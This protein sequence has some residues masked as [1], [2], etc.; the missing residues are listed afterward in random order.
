VWALVL[1]LL[2]A[3]FVDMLLSYWVDPYRPSFRIDI[4]KARELMRFGRWISWFRSVGFVTS[5]LPSLVVARV[6]TPL[7][8][9]QFQVARQI[10]VMPPV[11]LG[12]HAH[13]VLFPAL[14][15]L[16][17]DE[18]RRCAYLRALSVISAVTISLATALSVFGP[19][20]IEFG[21]GAHWVGT[22]RPLQ[23]LA[24]AGCLRALTLPGSALFMAVGLP[25]L[26]FQAGLPNAF[27][28]AIL[29][30]PV[31]VHGGV[32]GVSALVTVGAAA[33]FVCHYVL[34][35]RHAGI[36]SFA[37][38]RALSGGIMASLPIVAVIVIPD[39]SAVMTIV[40]TMLAT[41]VS[42][43]LLIKSLQLALTR[44]VSSSG[45]VLG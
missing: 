26:D 27:I 42:A 39:H 33:S 16:S 14:A 19:T 17:A 6:V 12:I 37:I 32:V 18:E 28:L 13:G 1:S 10:A 31:A 29:L 43:L 22:E 9:G 41:V 45:R 38:A 5:E 35:V 30:Y 11:T 44:P 3:S 2:T 8:L 25:R 34:M 21:L 36:A 23:I 7:A 40:V 4:A 24:W 20:L 15:G